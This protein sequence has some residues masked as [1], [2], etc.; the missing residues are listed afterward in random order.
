MRYYHEEHHSNYRRIAKRGLNQWNDLFDAPGTWTYDRFQ[1]RIFLERVLPQLELPPAFETRVFEY[2]C[3]TGPAACFLASLG[4]LV[5]AFDLVPEAI[6]I[7]REMAV[8]RGVE[9]NFE[10]ADV[11]ELPTADT[12][13]QYDIVLD[14]F[15]LQ[16]IV[17]DHDRQ[18]LF[19]AVLLRLKP[20]GY[21]LISTAIYHP[22]RSTE[23]P[24][25]FFDATTGINYREVSP[26]DD[27][28]DA[29]QI[30]DRWYLP[31]RRHVTPGALTREFEK[32]GFIVDE[33]SVDG[34]ADIVARS[35]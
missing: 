11:C 19:S 23:E 6:K 28:P 8:E 27:S 5:E 33:I 13:D 17:T 22:G 26:F 18:R 1:N 32:A 35:R 25:H 2:G 15:C 16:S 3:G 24:G 29:I 30:D 34:H 21:Y 31:H 4:Y 10:L 20:G 7:A 12:V 14:S 9:V